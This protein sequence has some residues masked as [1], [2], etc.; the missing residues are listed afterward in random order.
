M[1][2]GK[3]KEG[4]E[5]DGR[6]DWRSVR[7]RTFEFAD[8]V[9]DVVDGVASEEARKGVLRRCELPQNEPTWLERRTFAVRVLT[10]RAF[11]ITNAVMRFSTDTISAMGMITSVTQLCISAVSATRPV[12]PCVEA[13]TQ[14]YSHGNRYD[15]R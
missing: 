9:D 13:R 6:T 14:R 15:V 4:A 12:K 3:K 7:I 2:E 5:H 1:R 11:G 10:R 8:V